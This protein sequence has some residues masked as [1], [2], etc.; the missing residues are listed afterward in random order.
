[1]N[2]NGLAKLY[3]QLPPKERLPLMLAASARAH[4]RQPGHVPARLLD[5]AIITIDGERRLAG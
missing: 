2:T 4:G 3:G 5:L 1:M